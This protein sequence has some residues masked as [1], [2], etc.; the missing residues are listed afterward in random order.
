MASLPP[1]RFFLSSLFLACELRFLE[2]ASAV[3]SGGASGL[4]LALCHWTGLPLALWTYAVKI[5]ILLVVWRFLGRRQLLWTF[6]SATLASVLIYLAELVPFSPL[7]LPLAF[8]LI[9]IFSYM[10]SALLISC[11]YS[12]GGFSSIALI[13]EQRG[14]PTWVTFSAMNGISLLAMFLAYGTVSG[15]LSLVATLLGGFSNGLWLRSLRRWL[16]PS[17]LS[18]GSSGAHA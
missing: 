13:L 16:P 17:A 2:K 9:L 10:P 11:G 14:V 18:D 8:P 7:P 3:S 12:S 5:V 4:S 1:L 6:V 15:A